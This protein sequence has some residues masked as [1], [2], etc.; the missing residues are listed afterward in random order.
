MSVLKSG[1]GKIIDLTKSNC[2]INRISSW[3]ID[4]DGE[5]IRGTSMG[6]MFE[7]EEDP[8]EYDFEVK[9]NKMCR[10]SS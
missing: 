4:C 8:H 7:I 1:G 10:K 5:K 9:T 3:Y 2:Q 6:N